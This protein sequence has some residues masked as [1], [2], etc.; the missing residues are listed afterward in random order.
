MRTARTSVP[1]GIS[2]SV[3][4]LIG[5]LAVSCTTTG[6]APQKPLRISVIGT[7]D[8]HGVF[9][10]EPGRGGLATISGYVDALRAARAEDGGAVLLIDAGDM[11]QGTLESN[12]TEGATVV[13]AYNAMDFTAAAIGNHEFDFGPLGADATPKNEDR[14]AA[15]S[16]RLRASVSPCTR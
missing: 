12:L 4:L 5:W 15:A 16:K 6:P 14:L 2:T 9:L 8:I 7:N 11:W 13:E 3:L 1:A 10:P